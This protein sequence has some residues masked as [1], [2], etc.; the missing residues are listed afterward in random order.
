MMTQEWCGDQP[1]QQGV[2]VLGVAQTSGARRGRAGRPAWRR[3]GYRRGRHPLPARYL[4]AASGFAQVEVPDP[5]AWPFAVPASANGHG[6][7]PGPL[8]KA[9]TV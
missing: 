8:A 7:Q 6:G 3:A 9:G 4:P 5:R 2:G 1:A